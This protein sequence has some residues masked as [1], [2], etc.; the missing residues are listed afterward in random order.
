MLECWGLAWFFPPADLVTL[1]S[2]DCA[3]PNRVETVTKTVQSVP[4]TLLFHSIQTFHQA[5]PSIAN[6]FS[7]APGIQALIARWGAVPGISD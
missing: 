5:S 1:A 6:D 4:P 2:G 3:H 7:L